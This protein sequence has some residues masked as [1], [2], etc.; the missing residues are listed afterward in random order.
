MLIG[1]VAVEISHKKAAGGATGFIGFIAYLGMA[2][3]GT[4]LM[5]ICKSLGWDGVF[6]TLIG[7][8]IVSVLLLLPFWAIKFNPKY[9]VKEP[10]KN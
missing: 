3:A 4:P 6:Q 9:S 7:C 5:N 2:S 10:I 8:G 1:M